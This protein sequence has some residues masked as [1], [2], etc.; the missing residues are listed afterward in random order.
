MSE[1]EQPA[2]PRIGEH[3]IYCDEHGQDC[4][5]L[6][7]EWWGGTDPYGCLNLLHVSQDGNR[8]DQYGRQIERPSS[9]SHAQVMRVHGRYWRRPDEPRNPVATP[10][11]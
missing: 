7:T 6:V 1:S 10:A 9:V 2:C 3:V 4:D 11:S 5:A 8:R